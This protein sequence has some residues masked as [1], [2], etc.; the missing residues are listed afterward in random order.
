MA[1]IRT[2]GGFYFLIS[3]KLKTVFQI[4]IDNIISQVP[5]RSAC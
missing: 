2:V 5:P 1:L 3:R 4:C